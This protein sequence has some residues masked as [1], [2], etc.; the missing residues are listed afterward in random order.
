LVFGYTFSLFLPDKEGGVEAIAHDMQ[1]AESEWGWSPANID[2]PSNIFEDAD[3]PASISRASGLYSSPSLRYPQPT[4]PASLSAIRPSSQSLTTSGISSGWQRTNIPAAPSSFTSNGGAGIGR[5]SAT[6]VVDPRAAELRAQLAQLDARIENLQSSKNWNLHTASLESHANDTSKLRKFAGGLIG[7][8]S[9]LNGAS[10]AF[11]NGYIGDTEELSAVSLARYSSLMPLSVARKAEAVQNDNLSYSLQSHG[12][13]VTSVLVSPFKGQTEPFTSSAIKS[14]SSSNLSSRKAIRATQARM[15]LVRVIFLRANRDR[16]IKAIKRWVKRSTGKR[17]LKAISK[18]EA[19]ARALKRAK[20]LLRGACCR[21][22]F[23]KKKKMLMLSKSKEELAQEIQKEEAHWKISSKFDRRLDAAIAKHAASRSNEDSFQYDLLRHS[24]VAASVYNSTAA[25]YAPLSLLPDQNVVLAA[26]A[27]SSNAAS[28]MSLATA[29]ERYGAAV[30]EAV[31]DRAKALMKQVDD[32]VL[33]DFVTK[34]LPLNAARAQ[35]AISP[36]IHEKNGGLLSKIISHRVEPKPGKPTPSSK[37]PSA[38]TS[39]SSNISSLSK[40]LRE[41]QSPDKHRNGNSNMGLPSGSSIALSNAVPGVSQLPIPP[42]PLSL[43]FSHEDERKSAM[44]Q[45]AAA[46]EILSL[47]SSASSS[48]PFLSS[49]AFPGSS[50]DLSVSYASKNKMSTVDADLVSKL[51][52]GIAAA[53]LLTPLNK[54]PPSPNN[55]ESSLTKE[56][57]HSGYL[58]EMLASISKKNSSQPQN[59]GEREINLASPKQS[60]FGDQKQQQMTLSDATSPSMIL[61]PKVPSRKAPSAPKGA[62]AVNGLIDKVL[63]E[64]DI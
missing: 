3:A 32:T 40:Q 62:D 39:S 60:T 61:S 49:S 13:G 38:A 50:A 59:A 8:A 14:S 28:I 6:A 9:T 47:P 4:K 23:R 52:S 58:N 44:E 55:A 41:R 57:G 46:E 53:A 21:F 36:V 16:I 26:T 24:S 48:S 54:D 35:K 34:P 45:I 17:Q 42:L 11:S 63:D 51:R 20:E 15:D 25:R 2:Q 31:K 64:L 22:L 29:S 33:P 56:L 30:T 12:S 1:R 5:I 7:A 27:A 18:K 19:H 43:A 37:T 10:D